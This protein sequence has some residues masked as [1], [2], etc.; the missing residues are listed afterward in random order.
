MNKITHFGNIEIKSTDFGYSV[1]G[2]YEDVEFYGDFWEDENGL[3]NNI[4][5]SGSVDHK[6]EA[7]SDITVELRK[8][9]YG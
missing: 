1:S 3:Q 2:Y 7:I 5:F 6:H 4:S 8:F 9:Q